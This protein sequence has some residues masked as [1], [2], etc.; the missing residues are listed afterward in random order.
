VKQIAQFF[1]AQGA[2]CAM[3]QI[4]SHIHQVRDPRMRPEIAAPCDPGGAGLVPLAKAASGIATM[5]LTSGTTSSSVIETWAI[6]G[7]TACATFGMPP[8]VPKGR[9]AG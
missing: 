3:P 8:I 2:V 1:A 4:A 5:R 7:D 6:C 9:A